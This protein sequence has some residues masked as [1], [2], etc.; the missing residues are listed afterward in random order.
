MGSSFRSVLNAGNDGSR[1]PPLS[2][3][4]TAPASPE[5]PYFDLEID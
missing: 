1:N 3:S 5:S 2:S 4:A